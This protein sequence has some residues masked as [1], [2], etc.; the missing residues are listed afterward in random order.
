MN[1]YV[2]CP[3]GAVTGGPEAIHQ[4]VHTI[5]EVGYSAF[6][7]YLPSS[8]NVT[9]S[10]SHYNI[11][12]S[13][14]LVDHPDNCIVV[15][16]IWPGYLDRFSRMKKFIWWLSVDN[17][18][19]NW[20]RFDD[21]SITHL[22]QSTYAYKFLEER[23]V[24]TVKYLREF[25]GDQ[26]LKSA[27]V[28]GQV[29]KN[30]IAFNPKK[31]FEFTQYIHSFTSDIPFVPLTGMTPVQLREVLNE[32]KL[33]IDFGHHPGQDRLAREAAMAGCVIIT[34]VRGS[35]KFF[36]DVPI[37]D[38]YKFSGSLPQELDIERLTN[39][40]RDTLRNYEE[41]VADFTAIRD[42]CLAQ[43][44]EMKKQVLSIFN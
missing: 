26:H 8:D 15:P 40:I 30:Q 12:T 4:L 20:D 23:R 39:L 25:L 44:E 27:P 41:Y 43:P 3:A 7:V 21:S 37:L 10:Y 42:I 9:A 17:R 14:S 29:K 2:L 19:H 36:E 5:N 31:G 1:I 22:A 34:G 24:S 32:S 28:P 33:Y 35:A 18:D 11:P 6:M 13:R 16:E 38:K